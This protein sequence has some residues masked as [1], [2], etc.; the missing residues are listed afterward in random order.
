MVPECPVPLLGRDPSLP[1]KSFSY[2]SPDRRC[3]K[4]FFRGQ[5][6]YFYQ[7]PSETTP[8]WERPFMDVSSKDP[9][10]SSSVDGKFKPDYTPSEVLNPVTFLPTYEGSLPFHSCLENL[11]HW[12]K[13]LE[14]LSEDPLT[15]PE[16]IWYTDGSS[17]VMAGKRRV[18]FA[19]V[20]NFETIGTKPLPPGESEICSVVSNS[21]RP[22]RLQSPWNS[23]GQNTGVGRLSL[24]QRIFPT[25]GSN[26]GLATWYFSPIS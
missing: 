24:L 14:G 26:P 10:V 17:F 16:E 9:Q 23:P 7:P 1:L 2:Y 25:Q 11:D 21:L 18:R 20:S 22:H 5:T 19:V 13:P 8:E 15:D 6:N 12:T 3:F 4:T